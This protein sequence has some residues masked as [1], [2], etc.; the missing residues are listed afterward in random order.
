MDVLVPGQVIG[1]ISGINKQKQELSLSL[2][3][4]T[5]STSEGHADF[6]YGLTT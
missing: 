5:S 6:M 3:N 4:A 2:F 1:Y